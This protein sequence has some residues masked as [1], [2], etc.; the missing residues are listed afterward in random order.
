MCAYVCVYEKR[1]QQLPAVNE[2]F[3]VY[4]ASSMKQ[5][6]PYSLRKEKYEDRTREG[7]ER[8]KE[9]IV[10]NTRCSETQIQSEGLI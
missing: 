10:F 6:T 1:A 7:V 2:Q 9:I 4:T 8:V 5:T 3:T